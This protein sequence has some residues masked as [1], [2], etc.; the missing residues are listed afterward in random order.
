MLW[1]GL[2]V[3]VSCFLWLKVFEMVGAVK[4]GLVRWV[5]LVVLLVLFPLGVVEGGESRDPFGADPLGLI[6]HYD[7]TTELGSASDVFEVLF[8]QVSGG[9][10]GL[11]QVTVEEFVFVLDR[12][13]S[14][15]WSVMSGGAYRVS[16][17][18]GGTVRDPVGGCAAGVRA[19]STGRAR[20]ALIAE[21]NSYVPVGG[22]G[23]GSPGR[24]CSDARVTWWCDDSY[25]ANGRSALVQMGGG[26]QAVPLPSAVAHEMGHALAFPHS[27]TGLL[28]EGDFLGEYDNPMDIMSAG[29]LSRYA[30]GMIAVN[31]YAAGWIPPEQVHVYAGGTA[32]MTLRNWGDGTLMLAVPSDQEGLWLSVG[33]RIATDYNAAPLDGV[34]VYVVDERPTACTTLRGVCWG[35]E[36]RVAPYP[37]DRNNSLAHVLGPGMQLTWNGITVEVVSRTGDGYTVTVTDGT[38]GSGRFVDDDGSVH[39]PDIERIAALGITVGCATEPE[40]L[41]CPNRSVSRAEMAA[42]LV[43]A[44][45]TPA[46]EPATSRFSDVDI[47]KWYAKYAHA[48]ADMGIDSGENGRWRPHD[49]LT[50]LEMAYWLTRSFAHITPVST[51]EGKFGDVEQVH[52]NAVEGLHQTS[53]TKGCSTTPLRYC[54]DQPVTRAQMASFIIRA[55]G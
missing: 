6:A 29:G 34:E 26:P 38:K 47:T 5:L 3:C 19:V 44:L 7:L 48:I 46:P 9:P 40:P 37:T 23:T 43:R 30:V 53:V 55:L 13:V 17:V 28:P 21:V 2:D 12:L 20:A 15:Y 45:K 50:R 36:R 22:A 51:P 35:T 8:C 11:S 54:P 18:V 33:A 52:W 49:P 39:E 4:G 14:E 27:F 10:Y 24:W 31:R 42:F 41:F 25:P 32:E 16:F 1:G